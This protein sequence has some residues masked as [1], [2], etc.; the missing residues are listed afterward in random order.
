MR[1]ETQNRVMTTAGVSPLNCLSPS[2]QRGES[3][4][5]W[6]GGKSERP[7]NLVCLQQAPAQGTLTRGYYI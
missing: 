1:G 2:K 5:P 3:E 4:A 7:S 6:A